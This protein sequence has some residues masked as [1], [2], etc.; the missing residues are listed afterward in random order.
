MGLT[1]ALL[2][3]GAGCSGGG[4]SAGS[5]GQGG[6]GAGG[7]AQTGGV[8]GGTSTG[9]SGGG[10]G[11]GP[12]TPATGGGAGRQ[13][14]SGG[15]GGG[16]VTGATGGGSGSNGGARGGAAGSATGGHAGGGGTGAGASG[17]HPGSGGGAGAPPGCTLPAT[18]GFQHD[19]QPFLMKSC[20]SQGGDGC[21]VIDAASTMS[22]GGYDHAY[23][24]ITAGAHASS[25]PEKPTP[26]RYQVVVDV[27]E[28]ANPA[29]CSRSRKMPPTNVTG[30][31]LRSPLTACELATLQAWLAEPLVT[32]M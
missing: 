22:G 23:D 7:A 14:G 16:P 31:A 28:A 15:T 17:G 26:Y 32:Q 19:V 1:V 3:F 24:W 25:C 18:V 11:P 20:G 5:G 2:A 10:G 13:D 21:H 4:V 6:P 12:T 9:G 27:I 30:T 29:T 8:P